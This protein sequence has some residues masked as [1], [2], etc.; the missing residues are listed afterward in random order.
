MNKDI[1]VA[2]ECVDCCDIIIGKR[3]LLCDACLKNHRIINQKKYN[4]T[5]KGISSIH[6]STHNR[7][8]RKNN[9]THDFTKKEWESKLASTNGICSICEKNV[10]IDNLTLD[11]ILPIS[12]VPI[13]AVYT[14]DDVQPLCSTC[15]ARKSARI[16]S[17]SIL[18]IKP[19][20]IDKIKNNL[21]LEVKI[22]REKKV[23]YKK[24]IDYWEKKNPKF[25]EEEIIYL[26]KC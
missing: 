20:K 26:N 17:N 6:R 14:I 3:K 7:R 18:K 15:N 13:G 24:L 5:P 9:I 1:V 8:A 12:K 23:I 25:S 16:I 21:S 10:G 22:L 11:H 2:K 4:R 19:K